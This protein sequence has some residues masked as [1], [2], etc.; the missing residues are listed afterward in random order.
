MNEVEQ[1]LLL[2]TSLVIL[3]GTLIVIVWQWWSRR[4]GPRP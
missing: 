4:R 1:S 2:W 3:S